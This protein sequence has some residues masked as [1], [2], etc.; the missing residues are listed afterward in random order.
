MT[1]QTARTPGWYRLDG[2]PLTVNPTVEPAATVV[3]DAVP[4]CA[5]S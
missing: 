2:F 3:V 5:E 1:T 4:D